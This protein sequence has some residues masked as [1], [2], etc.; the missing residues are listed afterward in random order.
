MPR[1][2]P[3]NFAPRLFALITCIAFA[4]CTSVYQVKVEALARPGAV[5]ANPTSFRIKEPV[6]A[7]SSGSLRQKEIA[8]HV[9]TALSAHGLYEAASPESAD[10]VVEIDYGIG[11]ERVQRTVYEE[12]AFGRPGGG[13]RLKGAPPE[14]VAREM[15]GYTE[16]A[17]TIVVREK[18][19]SICARQNQA[20]GSDEPPVD[21]WRVYVSIENEGDD[22]RGHLPI[23]ASAAMDHLGRT[24][25]GPASL[26]LRSDDEAIRFIRKGM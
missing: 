15:M 17:D 22:L 25:D 7:A 9:R 14:G 20:A 23:L 4:G 2:A 12:L 13:G 21:V 6:G 26:T 18:H 3:F 19:M 24:T 8:S 5:A 10:L 16:L 11:P 1:H